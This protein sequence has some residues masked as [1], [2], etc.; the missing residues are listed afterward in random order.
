MSNDWD[1]LKMGELF[2]TPSSPLKTVALRERVVWGAV[3]LVTDRG[4][5]SEDEPV[6][7]RELEDSGLSILRLDE[8]TQHRMRMLL[9]LK[10]ER[11]DLRSLFREQLESIGFVGWEVEA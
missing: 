9:K 10:P 3:L 7:W 2:L 4:R 1:A 11:I 5:V 8:E 6:I